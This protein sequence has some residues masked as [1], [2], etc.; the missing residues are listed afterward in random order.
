MNINSLVN[1]SITDDD[2]AL[3]ASGKYFNYSQK[4]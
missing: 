1:R 2:E 4:Y 3:K